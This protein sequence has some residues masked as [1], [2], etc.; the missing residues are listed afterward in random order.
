M[1]NPYVTLLIIIDKSLNKIEEVFLIL[2]ESKELLVHKL[3]IQNVNKSLGELSC[4]KKRAL[5]NNIKTL[6]SD[7][8][9]VKEL[10]TTLDESLKESLAKL[11]S[12]DI[13]KE[14]IIEMSKRL[15][16]VERSV[17]CLSSN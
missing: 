15:K 4:S 12:N 16:K 13:S 7:L 5:M 8:T 11:S 2:K 14:E 9:N 10:Y 1:R 3:P 17:F 6:I